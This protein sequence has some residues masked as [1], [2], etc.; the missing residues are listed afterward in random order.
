MRLPISARIKVRRS[1]DPGAAAS[2]ALKSG[3]GGKSLGMAR[4]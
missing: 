4:P 3:I 2:I 1:A